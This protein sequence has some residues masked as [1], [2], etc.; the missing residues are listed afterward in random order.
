[1]KPRIIIVSGIDG[2][3][4]TT[5]IEGL[6]RELGREGVKVHYTWLRYNHILVK[7]IHAFARVVGLARCY[8]SQ[9]GKAWRHEF[10][11]S[12]KFCTFYIFVTWLDS[13]LSRLKFTLQR[14]GKGVDLIICDRWIND[15]LVD[16]AVD[17]RREYLLASKWYDRFQQLVPDGASQVVI[18]RNTKNILECRPEYRDDP[19]FEFREMMYGKFQNMLDK[20]YVIS[21]DGSVQDSID[22]LKLYCNTQPV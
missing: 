21:N 14:V 18:S 9:K 15:I 2:A 12:P 22:Q 20:V 10:Y 8:G 3:G 13:W 16:L 7:P 5:I 4:K 6:Q 1:M 17:T 19:D 11:R